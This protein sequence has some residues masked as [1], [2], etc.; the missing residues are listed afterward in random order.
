VLGGSND[1]QVMFGGFVQSGQGQSHNYAWQACTIC[2]APIRVSAFLVLTFLFQVVTSLQADG[3]WQVFVVVCGQQLILVLTVLCHEFGHGG[4][5]RAFGGEIDNILLWPFGGICF[6]SR[7]QGSRSPVAILRNELWVVLAGPA[8]HF[9][10]GPFWALLLYG[11]GQSVAERCSPNP[12]CTSCRGLE[13]IWAFLDP[14]GPVPGP[15]VKDGMVLMGQAA[16]LAW[17]LFGIGLR[18]NVALFLFNVFFPMYPADGS[19]ILAVGLMHCCGVSP[20]R[21]ALVLIVASSL[22]A[23]LLVCYAMY[24]LRTAGNPLQGGGGGGSLMIG[25]MGWMGAMSLVEAYRLWE[26]RS[27]HQL[28]L[29]PLFETARSTTQ[30]WTTK[31]QVAYAD[32]QALV[33][34]LAAGGPLLVA[35]RAKPRHRVTAR[36]ARASRRRSRQGRSRRR[37]ELSERTSCTASRSGPPSATGH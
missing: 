4:M 21:A 25:L 11:L 37:E 33:A 35:G 24:S 26:L 9:L 27:Q 15:Y 1:A 5:A 3:R 29:H 31:T 14:V 7:P 32:Q 22:C 8:T 36:G 30:T 16:S 12:S 18:L 19:K 13:C 17:E 28:H 23:T 34:S 6:S 10:M 2:R 20:R